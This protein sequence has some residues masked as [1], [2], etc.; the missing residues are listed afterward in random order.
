MVDAEGQSGEWAQEKF[1]MKPEGARS[2]LK[3]RL[4]RLWGDPKNEE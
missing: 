3:W 1:Q 4:M 2:L